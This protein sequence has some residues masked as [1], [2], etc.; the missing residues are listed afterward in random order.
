MLTH[1]AAA[2]GA[3]FLAELPDKTMVAT[4]VLTARFKR[5]GYVWLGVSCAFLVHV[6]LAVLL[7]SLLAKLPDRPV[8]A[9][10][11]V[12]FL[13]GGALLL[14]GESGDDEMDEADAAAAPL[15]GPRVAI[16]AAS[17]VLLAE[18]GDLT[19]L[20]TAGLASRTGDPVAVA[21]GAWL[22]LASVAALAVTAG[23][24]IERTI[25]LRWVSR[26]AGV[27]FVALALVSLVSAVRG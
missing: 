12:L 5:P 26:V 19:Q 13:V 20:A 22:A 10:V 1:F 3:V 24:W 16:A 6:V 18:L 14:R 15:S 27:V 23:R 4:L 21:V 2:F 17:V 11:G 8:D 7:G 25:P 9:A